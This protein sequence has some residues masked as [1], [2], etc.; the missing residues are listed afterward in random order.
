MAAFA[1]ARP[2]YSGL[3]ASL[4]CPACQ[5]LLWLRSVNY[6]LKTIII[7]IIIIYALASTA[8]AKLALRRAVKILHLI[9]TVVLAIFVNM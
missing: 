2:C 7:I 5:L 6:L 8:L 4:C 3:R 1:R 9:L